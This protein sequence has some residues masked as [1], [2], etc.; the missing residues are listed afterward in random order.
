[1][2]NYVHKSKIIQNS[3]FFVLNSQNKIGDIL[4]TS[5]FWMF[6][7]EIT[8]ILGFEDKADTSISSTMYLKI[9][10]VYAICES[11]PLRNI[12]KKAK[13]QKVEPD[14]Q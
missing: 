13:E 2:Y 6:R 3:F 10:F 4:F 5:T 1:M 11:F 9:A 12:R 8:L 14:G 7:E